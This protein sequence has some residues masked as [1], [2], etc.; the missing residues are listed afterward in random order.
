M[1]KSVMA[2]VVGLFLL[3]TSSHAI[4]LKP[5]QSAQQAEPGVQPVRGCHRRPRVHRVPRRGNRRFRHRHVGPRC[6]PQRVRRLSN[7]PR[8]WRRRGCIIIG[9][10]TYCP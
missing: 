8:D 6:R 3:T 9:P 2:A 1:L 5:A 7:R 4:G 10:V